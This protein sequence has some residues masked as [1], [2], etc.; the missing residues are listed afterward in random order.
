MKKE[1]P[2]LIQCADCGRRFAKD[3]DFNEHYCV[4]D[5]DY[6]MDSQ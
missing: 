2:V 1:L 4:P 5:W 6:L 3:R